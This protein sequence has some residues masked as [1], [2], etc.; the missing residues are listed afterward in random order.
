MLLVCCFPSIALVAWPDG[1]LF[2]FHVALL[3]RSKYMKTLKLTQISSKMF[4]SL[5]GHL[6]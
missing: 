5:S 3:A 6:F 2:S 1:V 4:G